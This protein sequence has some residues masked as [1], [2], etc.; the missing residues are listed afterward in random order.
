MKRQLLI[1][2]FLITIMFGTS[3]QDKGTGLEQDSV[4]RINE[5]SLVVT[6]LIDGSYQFRYERKLS[7]HISVGLGSA[8]KTKEGLIT[9]SG[10]D[11]E[12]LKTGDITYSGMKLIP[13]IRY[14]LNKTQQ[15]QL[16]G[17][18]F[19]AYAKYFHFS[20]GINGAY[21]STAMNEYDLDMDVNINILSV[22]LMVGYKLALNNRFTVDFLIF[23]PGTG[24][25]RY[26]LKNRTELPEEFY[27]D[28]N[29][30]LQNFSVF[31]VVHSDFRFDLRDR[32][33]SFST[34]S[35]RYGLT[36]GYTF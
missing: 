36:V 23:G 14:Y 32:S 2:I 27:E 15:Y 1:V 12:R 21:I 13:D 11:R 4:F 29:D 6:D 16:D 18:Y 30:A 17:F 34:L 31:D 5:I 22:G 9:I 20:S 19:G 24:N 33:T 7:D 10:I 35:F 3:A 28:L 25:H 8:F 26:K